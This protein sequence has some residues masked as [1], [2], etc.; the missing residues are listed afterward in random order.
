MTDLDKALH[1]DK[2]KS[3]CVDMLY[4]VS[5]IRN[6]N[7]TLGA[8]EL[9]DFLNGVEDANN[10]IQTAGVSLLETMDEVKNELTG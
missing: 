9:L 1:Q 3:A 4:W 10:M 2:L 6:N 5:V 8:E 7:Y